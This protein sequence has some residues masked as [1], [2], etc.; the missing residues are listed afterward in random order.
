LTGVWDRVAGFQYNPSSVLVV[1]TGLVA[2]AAVAVDR[3]WRRARNVITIVHEAGHAV[4]ALATGR[5]LTGIRLHSDTSGLTLSVGRPT[6]PGMVATVA[7]GHLSPSLLGLLGVAVLADG[8]VT[9]ALWVSAVLLVAMLALIRNPYGVLSVLLTGAAI[10]LVAWY[11]PAEAQAAFGHVA[12]WFLL[13]GAVRPVAEL[14]RQRR[15]GRGWHSDADQLARL[16]GTTGLLW[17]AVFALASS[18]ALALG[19][20]QLLR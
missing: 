10:V 15:S 6:G 1:V 5:R 7:A 2:F 3:V 20:W 4:A 8:L 12:T 13:L 17:V 9:I 11:A 18:A 19:G 14:Q 16:T